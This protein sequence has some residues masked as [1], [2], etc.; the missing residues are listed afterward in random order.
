VYAF[1]FLLAL[2]A[3]FM[4]KA[5]RERERERERERKSEAR[6]PQIYLPKG[7]ENVLRC[8]SRREKKKRGKKE[9]VYS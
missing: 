7:L 1:S 4:R 6:K 3:V 2:R 5:A 8:S 9:G